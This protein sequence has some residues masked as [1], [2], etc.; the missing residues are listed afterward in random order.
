MNPPHRCLARFRGRVLHAGSEILTLLL[1]FRFCEPQAVAEQA[2]EQT[3]STQFAHGVELAQK[4][5]YQAALR[6]FHDAY[7]ASPNVAVLY[8]IGQAEVALGRPLEATATL[9]RYLREGQDAI[10]PERRQQ[11]G[12]QIKLLESFVVALDLSANAN[13]AITV[14]GHEVGRTPLAS[15]VRLAAGTHSVTARFDGAT[16][17]CPT[18]G[19]NN[20]AKG[21]DAC[22]QRGPAT[23]PA[24]ARS[25]GRQAL[26]YALASAGV[27]LGAG[28]LGVYLWKRG[29]YQRWQDGENSLKAETPGTPSYQAHAAENQRLAGD[30]ST[31]NHTILGLSVAGG[32]LVMAGASLFAI[33]RLSAQKS[34]GLTVAWG[35]QSSVLVGCGGAW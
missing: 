22:A 28:A 19:P 2:L 26:P 30:L 27:A 16:V 7:A 18:T 17:S 34:A 1:L 25:N 33:D 29:E 8:N 31:A 6:A 32:V 14:D 13:A 11:V 5:D 12:D 4:G 9:S 21:V 10:S 24:P 3:A 20:A 23:K 15:P 35:G